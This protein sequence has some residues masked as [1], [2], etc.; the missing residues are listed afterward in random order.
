[1]KK[2]FATLLLALF[3]VVLWNWNSTLLSSDNKNREST[4][5]NCKKTV[6][7][8]KEIS[9]AVFN[10]VDTVA[11]LDQA[12]I[13][14][15][16]ENEAHLTES[17]DL[18]PILHINPDH[19]KEDISPIVFERETDLHP[20]LVDLHLNP[21]SSNHWDGA[22]FHGHNRDVVFAEWSHETT[23]SH[24]WHSSIHYNS[25]PEGTDE[26]HFDRAFEFWVNR[27]W[28]EFDWELLYD[29]KNGKVDEYAIVWWIPFRKHYKL[30][31]A[32]VVWPHGNMIWPW[33]ARTKWTI[34]F[35]LSKEGA[36]MIKAKFI[37]GWDNKH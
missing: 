10:D 16:T 25:A 12:K 6:R 15:L 31:I 14:L 19:V 33:L 23:G 32:D 26:I 11:V 4:E 28:F 13:D 2:S 30:L 3:P 7:Y 37:L 24:G 34:F 17:I 21:H 9:D 35:A 5:V 22:H 8:S 20:K 36:W 18:P 27:K 1:M 29:P